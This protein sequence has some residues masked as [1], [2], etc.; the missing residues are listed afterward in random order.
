MWE[1]RLRKS[2]EI[3]TCDKISVGIFSSTIP[4]LLN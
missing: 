4:L 1:F 3:N 2:L